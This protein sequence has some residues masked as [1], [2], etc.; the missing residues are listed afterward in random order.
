M[1]S[2]TIGISAMG[3]L[4]PLLSPPTPSLCPFATRT[5]HVSSSNQLL[6]NCSWIFYS[7]LCVRTSVLQSHTA[8]YLNSFLPTSC[9]FFL[10][11]LVYNN[12]VPLP[13]LLLVIFFPSSFAFTFF[14]LSS[15]I[16][17]LWCSLFF[18]SP[19]LSLLLQ[20]N[21]RQNSTLV[22]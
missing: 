9:D 22:Y 6:Y 1:R 4:L 11:I 16:L 8:Y 12:I 20:N 14:F 7:I 13:S 3:P 5:D 18:F 17:S 2:S 19:L 10:C 15:P 21:H